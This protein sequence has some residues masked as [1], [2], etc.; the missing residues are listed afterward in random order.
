[1]RRNS[2]MLQHVLPPGV[3]S[4]I[5]THVIGDDVDNQ[6]K[7][8]IMQRRYQGIELGPRPNLRIECVLINDVIAVIAPRNRRKDGR[9]VEMTYAKIGEVRDQRRRIRKPEA[10][11]KLHAVGCPWHW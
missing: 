4:A 1:M 6:S 11:V 10:S 7:P 9:R 3:E 8:A 2:A 5:D